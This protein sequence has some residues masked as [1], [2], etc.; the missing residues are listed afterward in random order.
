MTE[1][2]WRTQARLQRKKFEVRDRLRDKHLGI[3][4]ETQWKTTV[5]NLKRHSDG[6]S[7]AAE[8]LTEG[9][10]RPRPKLQRSEAQQAADAVD[11]NFIQMCS[12]LS[13]CVQMCLNLFKTCSNVFKHVQTCSN[14]FRYVHMCSNVLKCVQMCSYVFKCVQTCSKL[15]EMCSKLV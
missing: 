3:W 8:R 14:V 9:E 4:R 5:K 13:K 1:M 6:V 2:D 15:F 12:N 7:H 10:K 11:C